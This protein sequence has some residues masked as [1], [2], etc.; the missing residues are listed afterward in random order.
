MNITNVFGNQ[1]NESAFCILTECREFRKLP[2][3]FFCHCKNFPLI[4]P[5]IRHLIP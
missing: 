1:G 3:F 2:F 5:G 4:L